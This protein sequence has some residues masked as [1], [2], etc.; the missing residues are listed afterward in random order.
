MHQLLTHTAGL[1]ERFAGTFTGG[2]EHLVSLADY[3]RLEPPDQVTRPGSA[4]SYSS[5]NYALAGRVVEK[6]SGLTYEQYVADRIFGPIKMTATTA[7]QPPDPTLAKDLARG[8]RWTGGHQESLP[9]LFTQMRPSGAISAAAADMGRFMLALLGDGSVDGKRIL[10]PDAVKTVLAPQY[11]PDPRIAPR[12]YAFLHW[13]THG[14]RLLHHDG[15]LGDQIGMVML[16]P[17]DR[18]GLFVAS[19][20]L[21]GVANQ[22]L[23]PLLTYLVGPTVPVP[24][25]PPLPDALRRAPHVAGTY[26][27][28]DHTRHD[29]SRIRALMPM[30]QSRVIVESDGAIRWQ[31]RRWLEVEPLVFRSRDTPDYIVFRENRRGA[32]TELH[33]WGATYE[34]IGWA[35]QAPFHLSVLLTCVLAFIGY[36]LS[37][38]L[39]T[40]RRRPAQPEGRVARGC[41]VLVAIVNLVFV[42]GLVANV[43]DLGAV[44]PLPLPSV[45]LL[46]LPLA[47]V[48][49]TALLPALAARAWQEHW[50]TRGERLGY[51]TFAVVAVAFMTFLNYWKPLGIRY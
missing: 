8:Y 33:A 22:V 30:I 51:S 38:G 9:Y 24:P 16:A 29:M 26:R 6:L 27:D 20:A 19:N 11:T 12:G 1:N 46:S 25:P 44:T 42:V 31:G 32:I 49:A 48:A 28:Y 47:S 36:P 21:P 2:P 45:L 43:R 23:E 4:Y 37:R 40:L 7:Q 15:T 14:Q 34:R 50:W 13:F 3:F 17:A 10:S 5:S 35:E 41:A 39:R 18:F